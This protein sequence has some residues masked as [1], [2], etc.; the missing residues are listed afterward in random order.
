MI[1]EKRRPASVARARPRPVRWFGL[2]A[3]LGVVLVLGLL[4]VPSLLPAVSGQ[5]S[6]LALSASIPPWNPWTCNPN[7]VAPASLH[8]PAENPS[9]PWGRGGTVTVTL[10]MKVDGYSKSDNGTKVYIP[11]T[12]AVF[13]TAV[14]RGLWI[15][16]P[17]ENVSITGKGWSSP[18]RLNW[19]TKLADSENFS[20]ASAFFTTGKNAVMAAAES[21][22]L[23]LKFRWQWSFRPLS[24]GPATTG[25]WSS[26]SLNATSPN[27]PS[28]FYP[29]PFVGLVSTTASP[30]VAG[31]TFDLK[32][33]GTVANTSF[34]VVL[35]W[36]SNGTEIQSVWENTSAHAK[37]FNATVPLAFRNGTPVPAGDYFVHVHDVCEAIL[38]MQE[39]Y[40]TGK[41]A[42]S[43]AEVP[44]RSSARP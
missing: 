40:V 39:I 38:H 12:D 23:L 27:L 29:A 41:A 33:N 17:A 2:G 37:T 4:F 3:G 36:P 1:H 14:G 16:F 7:N 42:A 22:S 44:S 35:E 19:S 10:E 9:A 24:G 8:I 6:S 25:R 30:A 18:A 34:R 43:P 21:G 28:I 13:A 11:S 20:S 5:M 31:T 15:S 26:P 32:L